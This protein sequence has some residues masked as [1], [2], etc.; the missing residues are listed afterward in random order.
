[1]MMM[2]YLATYL[3]GVGKDYNENVMRGILNEAKF[4]GLVHLSTDQNALTYF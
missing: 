1:M 4:G 2:H 3:I